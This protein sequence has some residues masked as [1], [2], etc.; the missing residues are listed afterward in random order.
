MLIVIA[1]I[2]MAQMNGKSK[3]VK[4]ALILTGKTA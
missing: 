3:P 1:G 4:D 2:L